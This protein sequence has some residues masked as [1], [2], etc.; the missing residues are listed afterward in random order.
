MVTFQYFGGLASGASTIL[1][2]NTTFAVAFLATIIAINWQIV[3]VIWVFLS[4][5][6]AQF[7]PTNIADFYDLDCAISDK[8]AAQVR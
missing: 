6:C 8:V 4:A 7:A 3:H 1:A 2:S 5:N